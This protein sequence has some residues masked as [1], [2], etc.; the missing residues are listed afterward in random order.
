M[1]EN[2]QHFAVNADSVIN[3]LDVVWQNAK[4]RVVLQQMSHGLDVAEV[5]D[6]DYLNWCICCL[7][8]TEEVTSD[9]TETIDTYAN[10]SVCHRGRH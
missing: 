10:W 1:L 2:F 5:I 4:Y 8:C 9:A 3:R 7:H 6:R